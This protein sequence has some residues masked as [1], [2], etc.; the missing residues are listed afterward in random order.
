MKIALYSPYAPGN[1]GGGEKHLF[2][3]ATHLADRHQ[4]SLACPQ[5]EPE[6]ATVLKQQYQSFLGYSIKDC[7]WVSSPLHDPK[8][9]AL[10]KLLWTKQFDYLFSFTD[11]SLFFS[12]AKKNNLHF[13]VPLPPVKSLAQKLKL[14]N[15]QQ[16]NANSYFTKTYIERNWG[17]K[18]TDVLYPLIRAD[19]VS[20]HLPKKRII[21]AVGRFFKQLHSKR[22]DILV[23]MFE[24]L[25]GKL[26]HA[27][28]PWK[29]ILVG[30]VED[31]NYFNQIK[32]LAKGLPIELKIDCSRDE[33]NKLYGEASFFW[34]A[35]GYQVD[36]DANPHLVE[37][38][39]IATVEAMSAGAIPLV[40]YKGG[41]VEI[42]TNDLQE[43]GWQEQSE[44]VAKTLALI[45]DPDRMK[46]ISNLCKQ[47]AADF[48]DAQFTKSLNEMVTH[49]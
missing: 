7:D 17:I 44:C 18:I 38:F 19:Q 45:N 39:G 2:D 10:D 26:Q 34:H 48:G 3:I 5:I 9:S 42:L 20:N 40:V 22:Q 41:Q 37:H 28:K 16:K 33:L 35:A 49:D 29:L 27:A 32:Q 4:V 25:L 23:E 12:A 8:S 14:M 46:K 30:A 47:R 31:E 15:W 36:Q 13:Q 11:G 24:K 6:V 1:F 43:L 21:L